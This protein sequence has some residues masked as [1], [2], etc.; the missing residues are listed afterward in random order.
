MEGQAS[1]ENPE[2]ANLGRSRIFFSRKQ[3]LHNKLWRPTGSAAARVSFS[4]SAKKIEGVSVV[5]PALK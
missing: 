3:G 1:I 4:A 2:R 5:V